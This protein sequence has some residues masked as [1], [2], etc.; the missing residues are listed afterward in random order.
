MTLPTRRTHL[1]AL[2]LFVLTLG[3][4]TGPVGL[5]EMFG[6]LVGVWLTVIL[7]QWLWRKSRSLGSRAVARVT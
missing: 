4:P 2:V 6:Q 5:W 3:S 7:L 1:Y